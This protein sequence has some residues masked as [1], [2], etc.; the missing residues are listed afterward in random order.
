MSILG[1][2]LKQIRESK[3]I[4]LDIIYH[5]TKISV[6]NLRMLE[7]NQFE[8]IPDAYLSAFVKSYGKEIGLNESF[9][10]DA[11]KYRHDDELMTLL[12]N[13]D[14]DQF[15]IQAEKYSANRSAKPDNSGAV[16]EK[17]GN[18]KSKKSGNM[19]SEKIESFYHRYKKTALGIVTGIALIFIIFT[20]TRNENSDSKT[21][22]AM[23]FD[24]VVDSVLRTQAVTE[25]VVVEKSAPA[26]ITPKIMRTLFIKAPVESCY[27]QI[28]FP[29]STG[30][31]KIVDFIIPPNRGIVRKAEYFDL[32]VGRIQAVE[33]YLDNQKLT[34]PKSIGVVSNWR[35]DE[36]LLKKP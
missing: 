36:T 16:T 10:K 4:P 23:S 7:S 15:R 33:V 17:S 5:H 2:K 19:I 35:I 1:T 32:K 31:S 26:A 28:T 14:I 6:E 13:N 20:L 12:F 27:V 34:A 3:G 25:K 21:V 22:T 29:D 18:E 8:N 9:L 11:F 30:A 24:Q